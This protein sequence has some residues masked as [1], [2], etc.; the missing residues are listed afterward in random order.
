MSVVI[1]TKGLSREY[2]SYRREEGAWNAVKGFF[3]RQ[4]EIKP[5]LKPT[6]LTIE[7]GQ[8]VGLVGANG[9]GKT[10]LL[11]ILS[12]LIYPTGGEVSV[13]GYKPFERK[14]EFLRQISILLGQKAQLWWDLPAADSFNLLANIYGLDRIQAKKDWL[15]LAEQLDCS[16]QLHTQLRRLSLGE[17][18]KMEIIGSLLHRPKVLFLDEPTIGLDVLA[19][20]TIRVFLA[21]YV[22][23]HQPTIILTSH[24]MDDISRLADRLLLIGRGEIVYDGTVDGFVRHAEQHL[25]LDIQSEETDF[26][27]VIHKFFEKESSGRTARRPLPT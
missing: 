4:Y 26:E 21:E 14:S 18:M 23:E 7:G 2:K 16:A 11:K 12:G 19:Q 3:K 15:H 10:T 9:A 24:Y 20:N 13:L 25:K 6:T 1:E 22:K 5:A 8:I 17:R 27:Q